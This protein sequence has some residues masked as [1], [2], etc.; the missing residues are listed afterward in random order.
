[1]CP[2]ARSVSSVCIALGCICTITSINQVEKQGGNE[3]G[4]I[5]Q[6]AVRNDG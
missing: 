3:G 4:L 2:L 5:F 1:M 6:E